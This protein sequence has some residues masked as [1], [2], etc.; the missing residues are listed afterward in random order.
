MPTAETETDPTLTILP[1]QATANP[2]SLKEYAQ[3]ADLESV[4]AAR[5]SAKAGTARGDAKL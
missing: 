2:Q 1:K 5:S 4:I 3:Y